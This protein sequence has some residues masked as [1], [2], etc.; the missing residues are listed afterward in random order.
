MRRALLLLPILF[1][2]SA[3]VSGHL[4]FNLV[5][6]GKGNAYFLDVFSNRLMRVTAEGEV[7]ELVDF[8]QISPGER[9]HSLAIDAEGNLFAG[10]YRRER[11]WKV[12]PSGLVSAAYPL[13][14]HEPRGREILHVGVD[15]QRAIYFMDWTY[16]AAPG[17][18]QRFRIYQVSEPRGKPALLFECEEG[19]DDFL[20]FHVGS[21]VVGA[22]GT[23][24]FS[25]SHR[26]WKLGPEREL[27]LVAGS[28]E[29]G[30]ADGTAQ[31]ARFAGP[32][33]MAVDGDGNLLVAELSGRLRRIDS[34][35]VV[36]TLA[37]G[38]QRGYVDGPP[39]A[40]R[41]EQAFGVAVGPGE[42]L[43]LAEYAPK[44]EY[45]I[46]VLTAGEVRTLARIPADG[47]FRK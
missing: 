38:E 13:E 21:M 2:L 25:N 43:Y 16:G 12:A 45:R 22:D 30:Y 31:E 15:A 33:G 8:W 3:P 44:Q 4:A 29:K 6:D 46:R 32:Q 14:G 23:P 42:R 5:V 1:A 20:D 35:G 10:G 27:A 36:T 19:A 34:K 17:D 41:F 24:Y 28:Q 37:G 18:G 26:I 9:L 7:S 47:T 11:I 39:A 40:A